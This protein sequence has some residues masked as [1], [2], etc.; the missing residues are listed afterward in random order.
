MGEKGPDGKDGENG[1]GI[2]D[3]NSYNL[4][5]PLTDCLNT[6][7]LAKNS[8]ITYDR[9]GRASFVDMYG[10]NV[11]ANQSTTTNYC[12]FSNDIDSWDDTFNRWTYIGATTDPFGGNTASE[13]NLDVD[14]NS[15]GGTGD[16]IEQTLSAGPSS[17]ILTISFYIK[18][19][20]GTVDGLDFVIGST[21]YTMNTPTSDWVKVSYPFWAASNFILSINPRGLTGARVG[22]YD[23]QLQ[24]NNRAEGSIST[25]SVPVSVNNDYHINKQGA[26]GLLIE[27][28][29][30]NLVKNSNNLSEWSIT[31]GAILNHEGSDPFGQE[32]Q[33]IRVE[34]SS[35]PVVTLKTDTDTLIP[36]NTYSVSV[37]AYIT[38]GSLQEVRF[39]LGGG[40]EVVLPQI[41][42]SG[43]ERITIE[44]IAGNEDDLTVT[45]TSDNLTAE[46]LL[47]YFQIE[48]GNTTSPILTG[49]LTVSRDA[50]ILSF[51]YAYNAPKPSDNWSFI[52]GKKDVLNNFDKK[53]IFSNGEAGAN[54]FS[55]YFTEED[56]T[57]NNGGNTSTVNAFQYDKVAIVYNSTNVKIFGEKTLLLEEALSSTSFTASN[58]FLGSDG[59][60][61]FLN[62]YL[63]GCMFYNT[64]L[65]DNEILYLMGA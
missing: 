10:K 27:E 50:D 11:W 9:T 41:P 42:V 61:G 64:A 8:L 32:S 60:E 7:N 48:S 14:T 58:I 37:Y 25:N 65:S 35:L 19:I 6:N 56:L 3:V 51:P 53:F 63:Y 34:W 59:T 29:K 52:F 43:F 15:L 54:E 49:G 28:A 13:I 16:V 46:L 44:C 22:I 33:T 24:D 17:E 26:N 23:V 18:V 40:A 55:L 12:T 62:G 30:T 1:I 57:I 39:S 38:G 31:N 21:K 36:G 20:S 4:S 47:S 5:E 2:N 45:C